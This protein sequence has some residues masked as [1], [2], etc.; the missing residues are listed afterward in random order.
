MKYGCEGTKIRNNFTYWNF[1]KF[2]MEFE[3]KF[4]ECSRCLNLNEI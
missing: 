1:S 3:L 4:R 2:G